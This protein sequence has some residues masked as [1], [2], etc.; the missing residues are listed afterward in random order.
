MT[1]LTT[2]QLCWLVKLLWISLQPTT[3]IEYKYSQTLGFALEY[4]H[5]YCSILSSPL[6]VKRNIDVTIL[7]RCMCVRVCMHACVRI[8]VQIWLGH[9]SFIYAWIS[10]LFNSFCSWRGVVSFKTFLGRLKVTLEG[11]IYEFF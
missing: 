5:E 2:S 1:Y 4:K 9:N 6:A 11:H 3:W 7:L 10:K 8:S